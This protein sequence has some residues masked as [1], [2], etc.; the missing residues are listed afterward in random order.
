MGS[1][2]YAFYHTGLLRNLFFAK[3]PDPLLRA[4]L[5]SILALDVWRSDNAFQEMLL[6]SRRRQTWN[7]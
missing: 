5:I 4:G 1:L 6:K 3:H 7:A 2:I